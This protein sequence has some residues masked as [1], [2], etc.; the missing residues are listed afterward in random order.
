MTL[1]HPDL[2][3]QV[4]HFNK[5]SPFCALP[6]TFN[7]CRCKKQWPTA[8]LIW[9]H[10]SRLTPLTCWKDWW[11]CCW[12]QTTLGSARALPMGWLAWSK[13]W[14]SWPSS[15]RTSWTRWPTPS[16]TRRTPG[17]GRVR[18]DAASQLL[19]QCYGECCI[20]QTV[21]FLKFALPASVCAKEDWANP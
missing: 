2:S 4:K 3:N 14:A 1:I 11:V 17:R 6:A 21:F 10:P 9:C 12:P 8:C 16:R 7:L 13:A 20:I 15:S 19:M 18:G 5:S